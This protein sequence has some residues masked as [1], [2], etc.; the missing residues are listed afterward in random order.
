MD[1]RDD[2]S[3]TFIDQSLSA[4][5]DNELTADECQELIERLAE[6][7]EMQRAWERHHAINS[8]LR[9]ERVGARNDLPWERIHTKFATKT[10]GSTKS[11]LVIDF[12]SLRERYLVKVVG[13]MALAASIVLGV[14]LF[15]A[16]QGPV[17]SMQIPLAAETSQP[18]QSNATLVASDQDPLNR[19]TQQQSNL[20]LSNQPDVYLVSDGEL[21]QS[22]LPSP[23]TE[24]QSR[25]Y[26]TDQP[27]P[28]NEFVRFVS[29]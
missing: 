23:D 28:S 8:L 15:V 26:P 1:Q 20:P 19:S 16:M 10:T 4:A 27:K 3:R 6:Q 13:G 14:S 5:I 11:S 22:P 25:A 7:P 24:R 9:G 12:A 21:R 29:D 18:K 17:Q 2:E